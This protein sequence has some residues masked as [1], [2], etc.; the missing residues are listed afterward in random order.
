M[1]FAGPRGLLNLLGAS[2][3]A[4][5]IYSGVRSESEGDD[6]FVDQCGPCT[7]HNYV[8]LITS[9]FSSGSAGWLWT[10]AFNPK[11]VR[12]N[13]VLLDGFPEL[14]WKFWF[15]IGGFEDFNDIVLGNSSLEATVR[16]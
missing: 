4:I 11:R 8:I 2:S 7:K 1:P 9:F 5:C 15:G 12:D 6:Y 10:L 16:Q 3:A 13:V 14:N